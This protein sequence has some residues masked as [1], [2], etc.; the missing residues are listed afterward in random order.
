MLERH[1]MLFEA[2]RL[3]VEAECET[4]LSR[5]IVATIATTSTRVNPV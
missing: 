2:A 3:L 5:K 4:M 1:N